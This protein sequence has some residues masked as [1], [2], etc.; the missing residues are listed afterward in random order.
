MVKKQWVYDPDSGGI[1]IPQAVRQR[2]E[3]RLRRFAEEQFSGRY[4]RLEIRF[5]GQ[6]CYIDAYT[7]PEPSSTDWLPAD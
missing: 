2:M 5:R 1:K 7:E 4:S 3:K 6:F